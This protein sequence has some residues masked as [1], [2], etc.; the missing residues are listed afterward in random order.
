MKLANAVSFNLDGPGKRTSFDATFAYTVSDATAAEIALS[1]G[2]SYPTPALNGVATAMRLN[3]YL[4]LPSQDLSFREDWIANLELALNLWLC[5]DGIDI[6]RDVEVISI[7]RLPSVPLPPNMAAH[8]AASWM[9][10]VTQKKFFNAY[11]VTYPELTYL[12]WETYMAA[13]VAGKYFTRD[14]TQ[15]CRSFQWY[16]EQINTDL[17]EA[18]LNQPVNIQLTSRQGAI[19]QTENRPDSLQDAPVK[20]TKNEDGPDLTEPDLSKPIQRKELL[21]KQLP[22]E[23]RKP[24][25]PLCDECLE[26]VSKAQP[27]KIAYVDVSDGHKAHPHLGALDEN[28]KTGYVHDSTALRNNPPVFQLEDDLLRNHCTSRDNNYKMLSEKVFVDL[29]Y[30]KAMESSLVPRDKIFC[31]VYTIDVFHSKIAAVRETWG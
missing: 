20:V 18:I 13:A 24:A 21:K 3:T 28:G 14:L 12:A 16:A 10:D 8:V 25:K 15:K 7:E 23:K 22:G 19:I 11:I 27:I 4:N 26:I 1:N 17:G 29:E 31:L 5:A 30:D 6:L 9:D 2:E